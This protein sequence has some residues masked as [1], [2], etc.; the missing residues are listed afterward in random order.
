MPRKDNRVLWERH[1]GWKYKKLFPLELTYSD[2]EKICK[3]EIDY[4]KI[5]IK[6]IFL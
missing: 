5:S 2:I 3:S 1:L 4:M 6:K